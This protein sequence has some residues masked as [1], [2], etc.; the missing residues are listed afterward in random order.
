M[1][2]PFSS[3]AHNE[4]KLFCEVWKLRRDQVE[5]LLKGTA[6]KKGMVLAIM[7]TITSDR[8]LRECDRYKTQVERLLETR[9]T[10]HNSQ[11]ETS[12]TIVRYSSMLSSL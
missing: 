9:V 1:L 11:N 12:A 2:P 8:M 7:V 3:E 6:H 4:K 10:K 5:S